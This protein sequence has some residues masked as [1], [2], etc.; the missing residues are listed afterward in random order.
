MKKLVLASIISASLLGAN[1]QA[2]DYKIDIEGQHAFI[3]FK[4]SHLGYSWLLGQFNDFEGSFT[5]DEKNPSAASVNVTIDMAS[6]DTAH[7]ERDKHLRS[8]DFFNVEKYPEASFSSTSYEPN[9]D[10][11]GTLNG[12]L[13]FFG[14]TKPISIAVTE[15]GAGQDPWGGFRRGFE[16]TVTLTPSEWGMN[17]DLGPAAETVEIYLSIEGIRQ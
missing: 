6:L 4:I 15:V 10:G 3:Q 11:T 7:A 13:T 5:Y 1:A 2:A 17:Y 16:G 8:D 14:T 9:G 12:N